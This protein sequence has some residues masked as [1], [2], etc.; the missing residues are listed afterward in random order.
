MV[1]A[2]S[3]LA[4]TRALVRLVFL[5]QDHERAAARR[6]HDGAAVGVLLITDDTQT[7]GRGVPRHRG[8]QIRNRE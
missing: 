2:G 1:Q 6:E 5:Q 8:S 7:E 4:E 3:V